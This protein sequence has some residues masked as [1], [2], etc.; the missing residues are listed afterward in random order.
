MLFMN[1]AATNSNPLQPLPASAGRALTWS[2]NKLQP[3]PALSGGVVF[4]VPTTSQT[5]TGERSFTVAGLKVRPFLKGDACRFVSQIVH[6]MH[7]TLER[8]ICCPNA[9][10]SP[11]TVAGLPRQAAERQ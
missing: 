3:H 8:P 9:L 6:S 10:G 1:L 7:P 5:M 11:G 2:R 4:F